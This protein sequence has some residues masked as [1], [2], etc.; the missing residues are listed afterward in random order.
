MSIRSEH[1]ALDA[2][3]T[4]TSV[5]GRFAIANVAPGTVTVEA[6]GR[7]AVGEP[8]ELLSRAD[9]E[10]VADEITAIDMSPRLGADR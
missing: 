8:L 10:V 7:R 4:F 5:S 1:F 6:F 9:V 2:D 3:R